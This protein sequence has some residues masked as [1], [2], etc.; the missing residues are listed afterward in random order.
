MA[1]P[2]VGRKINLTE[3]KPVTSEKLLK[4]Y[5]TTGEGTACSV[6]LSR[7]HHVSG[8]VWLLGNN[9]CFYGV[10]YYCKRAEGACGDGDIMEG[11]LS[12]WLPQWYS[13]KWHRH[14]YQRTYKYNR[15]ARWVCRGSEATPTSDAIS[16][17]GGRLML[18]TVNTYS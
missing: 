6:H 15:K 11:S 17:L 16:P 13:L 14:P 2:V 4:T 8:W 12:L 5:F 9:V 10:C 1:P 7:L 3:L 18:C